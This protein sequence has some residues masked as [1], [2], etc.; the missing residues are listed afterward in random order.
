M[1]EYTVAEILHIAADKYLAVKESEYWTRGGSKEKFSCCAVDEAVS[2]LYGYFD[3]EIYEREDLIKRI[4]EGLKN[5][6][7][8][9]GSVDAFDD[10]GEFIEENQQARYAW[11]KFAATMAE[12]QGV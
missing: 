10:N 8:P 12:E 3:M 5:M 11:L 6:G 4:H 7:C 2:R 1:K 9:T